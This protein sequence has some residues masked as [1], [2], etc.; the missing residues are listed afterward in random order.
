MPLAG[1]S[2]K[3]SARMSEAFTSSVSR[4][5][6]QSPM[7][8]QLLCTPTPAHRRRSNESFVVPRLLDERVLHMRETKRFGN[9]AGRVRVPLDDIY[10]A[11]CPTKRSKWAGLVKGRSIPG[12]EPRQAPPPPGGRSPQPPSVSLTLSFAALRVSRR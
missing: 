7:P 5:S 10:I 1:V 9:K 8:T 4:G 12:E 3:H 2:V 6:L 11:S